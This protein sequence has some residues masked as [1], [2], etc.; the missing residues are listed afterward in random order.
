MQNLRELCLR[1]AGIVPQRMDQID[2][3]RADPLCAQ[4]AQ[5]QLLRLACDLR[6]LPFRSVHRY[7]SASENDVYTSLYIHH[8]TREKREV[9][10]LLSFSYCFSQPETAF[11]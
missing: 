5:N 10:R 6:N 3:R 2:L 11:A 9:N 7:A 1:A 8:Y 4:H